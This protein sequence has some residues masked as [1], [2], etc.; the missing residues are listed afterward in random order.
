M[1]K[2]SYEPAP[3]RRAALSPSNLKASRIP[4]RSLWSLLAVATARHSQRQTAP[5]AAMATGRSSAECV[6]VTRV[7]L[8]HN[9]S[10]RWRT[11]VHL[12]AP[13]ASAHQGAQSAVEEETVYVDNAPVMPMSSDRC[14]ES[15]ANVTTSTACASKGLCA[16]VSKRSHLLLFGQMNI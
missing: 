4:C 1:W 3:K 2:L 9:A 12:T 15:T 5:S 13:T 16:P 14:G 10:A 8:A 11:T 7:G 6:S